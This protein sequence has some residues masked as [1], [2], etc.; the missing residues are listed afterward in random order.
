LYLPYVF[1][2]AVHALAP[3]IQPDGTTYHL[4]LVAEYARRGAFSERI[5]FFEVLPQG[6][7]MLFLP[8]F[9]V[10]KHSAAKLVHLGFLLATPPL[11][12]AIGRRLDLAEGTATAAA[13]LYFCT[14]VVGLTGTSTYTDAALVFFVLAAFYCLLAW[15]QEASE[16]WLWLAGLLAGFCY[17]IKISALLVPALALAYVMP[18]RR[19][20]PA[21]RVAAAALFSIAPWMARAWIVAG[22]PLAPLFNAWF[23]NPYFYP[24]MERTLAEGWR[25]YE[26]FSWRTAPWELAAGGKLQGIFGPVY[27]LAPLALLS[28]RRRTGRLLLGAAAL[29]G[30]PWLANAGARFLM[31]ALP[32]VA[33]ALAASLPRPAAWAVVAVHAVASWPDAIALYGRPHTWRLPDLPLRAALRLEPERD[34]LR[35]TLWEYKVA[36]FF[37]E[38]ASPDRKVFA[39]FDVARAYT[40]GEIVEWWQSG[41]GQRI[42]DTL[43]VSSLY[44]G[45]P[46][47]D[48]VVEFPARRFRAFRFR[49]ARAHRGEW[50]IHDVSFHSGGDRIYN[51]PQW[52]LDAW[53]N[54]WDAPLALDENL[55]TRW[56]TWEPMRAGMLV[57]VRFDRPQRLTRATLVSHTPVHGVPVEVHG[58]D[59]S[60][61]WHTL[62]PAMTSTQRVKEDLRRPAI[63]YLKRLGIESIMVATEYTGAWQLGRSLVGQEALWGLVRADERGFVYL[64]KIP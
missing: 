44:A 7:E 28:L 47:F 4:G 6:M 21:A 32:F 40:S 55:A 2:Y 26:G 48:L 45:D 8:A 33:L 64:L 39:L 18:A 5:A 34:Y 56:R 24:A 23:P 35:R 9:L 36:E 43:K 50:C 3:E 42:V 15:K 1:L 19:I 53:P 46:L 60:G 57:E 54:R 25:N 11:L 63:R 22:N 13:L 12:V 62:S 38:T 10:G 20:G 16:R 51:S 29:L 49:L 52:R 41:E 61:A 59:D 27:L 58:Q 17:A 37:N 14:P 30:L 31:P